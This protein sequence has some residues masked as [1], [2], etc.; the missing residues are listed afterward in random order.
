MNPDASLLDGRRR[1]VEV[2]AART[3]G[4]YGLPA[5]GLGP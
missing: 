5:D 1:I 4:C 2:H 3:T